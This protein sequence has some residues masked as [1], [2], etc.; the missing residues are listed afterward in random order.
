MSQFEMLLNRENM[1]ID[2]KPVAEG[3]GGSV[4]IRVGDAVVDLPIMPSDHWPDPADRHAWLMRILWSCEGYEN[5][6]DFLD[7]CDEYGHD[8]A[9]PN[10]TTFYGDL[11]R[12]CDTLR[13]AWGEDTYFGAQFELHIGMAIARARP[14]A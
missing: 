1:S 12:A 2:P 4:S 13:L 3:L 9:M 14:P 8:P 11:G 10:L 7:W 5:C 6:D